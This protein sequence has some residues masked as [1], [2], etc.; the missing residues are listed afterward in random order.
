MYFHLEFSY[1]MQSWRPSL[2]IVTEPEQSLNQQFLSQS[3][4][5]QRYYGRHTQTLKQNK[6]NITTQETYTDGC[7][8]EHI[9]SRYSKTPLEKLSLCLLKNGL[10]RFLLDSLMFSL[11]TGRFVVDNEGRYNSRM[12]NNT[13]FVLNFGWCTQKDYTI[14]TVQCHFHHIRFFSMILNP[15]TSQVILKTSKSSSRD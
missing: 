13:G 3:Q 6:K 15:S 2:G 10:Q 11:I 12:A 14:N 5:C 9:M 1:S 7:C 8:R 4:T